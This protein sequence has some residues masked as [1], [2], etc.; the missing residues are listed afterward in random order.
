MSLISAMYAEGDVAA[1]QSA[2]LLLDALLRPLSD[3]TS[4]VAPLATFLG[5]L[6]ASAAAAL[7][8]LHV[9]LPS[10]THYPTSPSKP[11]DILGLPGLL[12]SSRDSGASRTPQHV[13]RRAVVECLDTCV[14]R[15][16][17]AIN[18]MCTA[19]G[20]AHACHEALHVAPALPTLPAAG[21][22]AR[23]AQALCVA[24]L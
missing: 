22:A 24:L 23:N 2:A 1:L 5:T 14:N 12:Q 7:G 9:A 6:H 13:L 3:V 8:A 16:H 10:A 19:A 18:E 20:S 17:H 15:V 4:A 21:G 11:A